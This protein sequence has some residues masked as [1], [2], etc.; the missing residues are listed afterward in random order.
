MSKSTVSV[1]APTARKGAP[2]AEVRAFALANGL[3]VGTRGR[4]SKEVVEAFNAGKR[5][6]QRYN[7]PVTVEKTVTVKFKDANGKTRE[8]KVSVPKVRAAL[9]QSGS[10]VGER[11]RLK[12][13]DLVHAVESLA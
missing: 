12:A 2:A 5:G 8:R 3:S 4:F 1:L 7:G 13:S 11:G 10:V 6:A 9:A